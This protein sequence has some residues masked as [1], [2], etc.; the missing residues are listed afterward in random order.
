MSDAID[1]TGTLIPVSIPQYTEAAD[2]Q[3]AL[4]IYHYGPDYV[5]TNS[6]SSVFTN[7]ASA[8]YKSVAG[9]MVRIQQALDALGVNGISLLES[10][11][12]L[13]SKIATG[14][15]HQ[16]SAVQANS[17]GSANYP[18]VN[19]TAYPGLLVVTQSENYVYQTY[20]MYGNDSDAPNSF[21]WRGRDSASKWS[22]WKQASD[23]THTH[24]NYINTTDFTAALNLKQNAITGALS[25]ILTSNLA[26]NQVL[27]TDA[28]GKIT[29]STDIDVTELSYLNGMTAVNG[30][31]T[32][33]DQLA[34]KAAVTHAA[35]HASTGTDPIT[36]AQSQ[37]TNLT[38]TL[39]NKAAID[40]VN[41]ASTSNKD[42]F[43]KNI[44]I[45][46]S[47]TAPTGA[48]AGDIWLW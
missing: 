36:V 21:W 15:Y 25:N 42:N 4:R 35:T 39:T 22:A 41:I 24:A 7:P 45:Y 33:K 5:P 28:N 17:V 6:D 2:I 19:G 14:I 40:G 16:N 43:R 26:V 10:S 1:L 9:Y 48:V 30:K 12:N 44:G 20:Q 13:N 29:A 37:V 3:K 27:V 46:V 8:N 31:T 38:T 34:D 47:Q 32:I 11:E 23:T 18:T